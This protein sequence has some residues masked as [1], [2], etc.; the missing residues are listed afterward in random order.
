MGRDRGAWSVG[1]RPVNHHDIGKRYIITAFMFL[2]AGG[3]KQR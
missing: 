1:C 2:L 3:S